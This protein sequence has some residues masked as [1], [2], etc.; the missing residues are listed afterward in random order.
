MKTSLALMTRNAINAIVKWIRTHE[1]EWRTLL[2]PMSNITAVVLATLLASCATKLIQQPVAAQTDSYSALAVQQQ[3]EQHMPPFASTEHELTYRLLVAEVA[4]HRGEY[5]LAAQ[6]FITVAIALQST[7]LAERAT[8]VALYGKHYD[9][10]L[11]A[12]RLWATL[13][14][15]NEDVRQLLGSLLLQQ[16]HSSEAIEHIEG[17]LDEF[18]DDAEQRIEILMQAL[19]QQKKTQASRILMDKLRIKRSND[20]AVLF[21]DARLYAREKEL[22]KAQAALEKLLEIQPDHTR[23]VAFYVALLE[24]DD[25][26]QALDYLAKALQKHPE[27]SDWRFMYARMLTEQQ[28]YDAAISQFEQL[29]K[30]FPDSANV[31]NMLGVLHI[32]QEHWDKAKDYFQQLADL[33]SETH[34]DTAHYFLAQIAEALEQTEEALMQYKQVN[35]GEHYV[36]AQVRIALLYFNQEKT[37]LALEHLR[38]VPTDSPRATTTLVQVEAELLSEQK[39]Y[40]DAF[41][42]YSRALEYDQDNIDLL[43]SRAM[44][45]EKMDKLDVLE[46]DL[47]KVLTLS[48]DHPESLNALGYTLAD[49]TQRY[50]EAHE[51]IA[52]A[53][54]LRP[55]SHYILDSM[56]WVLYRMRRYDE[57]L[58]HLQR[59]Y[60]LK[61]DPEIAA[62]LGEVL[63]VMGKQ[64]QAREVWQ[65]AQHQFPDHSKLGDVI[66]RFIP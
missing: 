64:D 20:I 35:G 66:Q 38:S 42:V 13:D 12:V 10:A 6:N 33:D 50:D 34:S 55:N 8:R 39:R 9:L 65:D 18:K 3:V 25:P 23:G 28:Q 14:Q 19:A 43:Y 48:P 11:S 16:N 30:L 24:S 44:L 29:L 60:A 5:A 62:H 7:E 36:N 1:F 53:L 49:R 26:Q 45:A 47:R 61:I 37:E 46:A 41:E 40:K 56:G 31:I 63:W 15:D 27:Q 52:K 17:L 4:G 58:N 2:K 57:A 32:Q 21:V 59:A 51:L 54:T 22:Q